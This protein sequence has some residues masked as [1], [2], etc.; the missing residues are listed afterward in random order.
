MKQKR[1]SIK[2]FFLFLSFI[3]IFKF[4]YCI[5]DEFTT[6]ATP[7]TP[8]NITAEEMLDYD[9]ENEMIYAKKN[10]VVTQKDMNLTADM[11]IIDLRL[12]ELQASGNVFLQTPKEMMKA[13][14]LMLNLDTYKGVIYDAK[15]ES[16]K[17]YF[18]APKAKGK[19]GKL[20]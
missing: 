15:G 18:K 20:I 17:T 14:R 5:F 4:S 11:V 8:I 2:P 9:T 6:Q 1:I 12:K 7:K 3:F 19:S 13:D 16:E 10:V